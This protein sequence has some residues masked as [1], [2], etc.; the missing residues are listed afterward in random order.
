[1]LAIFSKVR[2][3]EKLAE[4]KHFDFGRFEGTE[5]P[6]TVCT[7]MLYTRMLLDVK[8][9]RSVRNF[10]PRTTGILPST[11]ISCSLNTERNKGSNRALALF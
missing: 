4:V 1:M 7:P 9:K 2:T 6:V 8:C 11:V 5:V 3:C 10:G